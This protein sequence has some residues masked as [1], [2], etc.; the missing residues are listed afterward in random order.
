MSNSK[1]VARKW[2]KLQIKKI[3]YNAT[4]EINYNAK[5]LKSSLRNY[6]D[7]YILVGGGITVTA[8]PSNIQVTFKN[9][10][11]FEIVQRLW[12]NNRSCWRFRFSNA[13]VQF[14]RI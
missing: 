8:S 11:T 2:Y 9:C 1:F 7:A 13:S 12:N 4:N 3:N 10:A 5:I 14:N 6:N